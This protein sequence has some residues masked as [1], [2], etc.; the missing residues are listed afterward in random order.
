[1]KLYEYDLKMG[2]TVKFLR[3]SKY[4]KQIAV[5]KG[6]GMSIC[7]Y[8]K[9]ESG[10]YAFTAGQLK[11]VGTIIDVPFIQIVALAD[12]YDEKTHNVTPLSNV[13]VELL[14]ILDDKNNKHK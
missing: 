7:N 11:T 12:A 2:I 10:K 4:V 6:L 13:V 14:K 9:Y 1:M 3:K 8:S 5:A